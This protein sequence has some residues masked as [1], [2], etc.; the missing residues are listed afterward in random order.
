MQMKLSIAT[1]VA[2]ALISPAALPC[3]APFGK[4]VN[5][6]PRQDIVVVHK[7]GQETYVFQPRFCGTASEFGLILPVPGKLSAQPAL[8]KPEVFARL[9]EVSQPRIQYQ[10]V[11]NSKNTGVGG[12]WGRSGLD[13]GIG[14]PGSATVVSSGTVGFMDYSQIEAATVDALTS[15]LDANGYPYDALAQA[16]FES[17]V[18]KSWY[19][20]AFRINQGAVETGTTICKDLGPIKL[21]FPAVAPVVPTRMATARARDTSGSLSYLSTF[22]WRIFGITSGSE[23]IGF[24]VGDGFSRT[25]NFSGLLTADDATSLDSLAVAG[26]RAVKLTLSFGYGTTAPDVSLINVEG[27]DYRETVYQTVYVDCKD[28]GPAPTVDAGPAKPDGASVDGASV[29]IDSDAKPT[30]ALIPDA[31]VTPTHEADAA[32][33]TQGGQLSG[34]NRGCSFTGEPSTPG[35]A[36]VAIVALALVLRRRRRSP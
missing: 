4:G 19:F 30:D 31:G 27:K 20:V 17:Y 34:S 22:T 2:V 7:D 5:V 3:G 9:Q 16:A 29:V 28:G 24:G 26:D 32:T 12:S 35:L 21:T 33:P 11:C 15:W 25:A 10:E 14:V 1:L 13:A 18:K 36:T 6:D 23:Q 8:S